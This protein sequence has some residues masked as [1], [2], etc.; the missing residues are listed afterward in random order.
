[1]ARSKRSAAATKGWATRRAH[2]AARS[3]AAHKGW[4]TRRAQAERQSFTHGQRARERSESRLTPQQKAARIRAG[5]RLAAELAHQRRSAASVRG[6]VT[7]R[8]RAEGRTEA[9][10][11]RQ[12]RAE[13]ASVERI[14]GT[15]IQSLD[16]LEDYPDDDF[17]EDFDL[18]TSPDYEEASG[19]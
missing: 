8:A 3:R 16:D 6:W 19:S 5:N 15:A 4:Q 13:P 12:E 7:R 17:G 14:G 2:A 9:P 11:S 18:E 1:M 10:R